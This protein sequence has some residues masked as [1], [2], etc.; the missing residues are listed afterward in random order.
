MV[1]SLIKLRSLTLS[2]HMPLLRGTGSSPSRRCPSHPQHGPP[3]S[4]PPLEKPYQAK[5]SWRW[6]RRGG[7]EHAPS[8]LGLSRSLAR[9][10]AARLGLVVPTSLGKW[11]RLTHDRNLVWLSVSSC[12]PLVTSKW[13]PR[14]GGKDDQA[15]A[16]WCARGKERGASQQRIRASTMG[17]LSPGARVLNLAVMA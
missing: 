11:A 4:L 6:Q 5:I 10:F 14:S 16:Y 1:A 15:G 3:S 8:R 17:A 13:A 7:H 9:H 12:A 2:S